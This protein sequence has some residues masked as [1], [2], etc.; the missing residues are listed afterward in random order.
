LKLTKAINFSQTCKASGFTLLELLVVVAIIGILSAVGI[1]AYS[2]YV[3]SS[4]TKAAENTI[5]QIS[6]AQTEYYSDNQNYWRNTNSTN[7]TPSSST[8]GTIVSQLMGGKSILNNDTAFEMCIALDNVDNGFI[9]Q[10]RHKSSTCALTFRSSTTA[11][12]VSNCG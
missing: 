10:A 8:S 12:T 7:C 1:F 3:S 6:L 4:Q 11:I 2:G 5:R 9:V